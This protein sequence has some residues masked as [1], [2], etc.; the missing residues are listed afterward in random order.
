MLLIR[1]GGIVDA[2]P[3]IAATRHT[4]CTGRTANRCTGIKTIE[5]QT[6]FCHF[7]EVGSLDLWVAVV[8]D[9]PPTL[10]IRHQEHHVG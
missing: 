2:Y 7:V 1:T 9:I 5:A 4:G 8:P 6:G 3:P 10:I